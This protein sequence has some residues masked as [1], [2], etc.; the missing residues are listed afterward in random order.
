MSKPKKNLAP[1]T[2]KPGEKVK[3]K[4]IPTCV[5]DSG[6][7]KKSACKKIAKNAVVMADLAKKLYAENRRSILLVL[8]GMDTAGK[9]GTIRSVMTGMNPTSCQ[10]VSFKKP[11]EEELDHDFLWRCHKQVPRRGNIGIFNRSHYEDVLIVRVHSLVPESKWKKR[12][13]LINDFEKLL[14]STDTT[15][16]K[17]FLHISKETQRERLQARLDDPAKHWKFNMAD[18]DERKLWDDYQDAY[19]ACLEKCSTEDAPWHVIP[20][21]KKWCRNLIVSEL[22]RRTLEDLNPKFPE[23]E[24]NYD[25][26]EVQ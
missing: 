25:G 1:Y 12:Y 20:S 21:D 5:A 16:V 18:L 11:S 15:M 7:S 10:V 2:I 13:E 6:Y 24:S 23:P 26:V 8:Q 19:A 4:D 9:D 3:L 14:A 22:L 17:C